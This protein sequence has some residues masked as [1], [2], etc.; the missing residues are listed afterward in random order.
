M[1]C[2]IVELPK[3]IKI[4]IDTDNIEGSIVVLSKI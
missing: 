1:M 2:E 3:V 4:P